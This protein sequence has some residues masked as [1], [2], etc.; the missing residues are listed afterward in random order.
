[1]IREAILKGI[2]KKGISQRKCAIDNLLIPQSFNAFL[3]GK[4]TLPFDD[5]EKVLT[6]LDLK[7][8]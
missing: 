1:M 2:E 7:V 3:K 5:V 8:K 4:R 6:Y